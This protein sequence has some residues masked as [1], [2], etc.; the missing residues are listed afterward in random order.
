MAS[1]LCFIYL[2]EAFLEEA[3]VKVEPYIT[4]YLSKGDPKKPR[5]RM[6]HLPSLGRHAVRSIRETQSWPVPRT[7][8]RSLGLSV[9]CAGQRNPM[10]QGRDGVHRD[11]RL[12]E[13]SSPGRGGCF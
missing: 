9:L 7:V 6:S 5:D 13:C 10:R 1:Q 2:K 12:R 3:G 4:G 11:E 8:K